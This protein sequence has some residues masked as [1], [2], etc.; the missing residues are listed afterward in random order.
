M[1][2]EMKGMARTDG[3]SITTYQGPS[4]GPDL[5]V[6]VISVP[7]VCDIGQCRGNIEIGRTNVISGEQGR[8]LPKCLP[9]SQVLNLNKSERCQERGAKYTAS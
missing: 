1:C 4:P 9:S 3:T 7:R 8:N 6:C 5:L 2:R